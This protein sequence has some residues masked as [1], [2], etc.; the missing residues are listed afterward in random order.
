MLVTDLSSKKE[1][2]LTPREQEKTV[3]NAVKK[4]VVAKG[5]TPAHVLV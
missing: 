3:P 5:V 1:A 4:K 2:E